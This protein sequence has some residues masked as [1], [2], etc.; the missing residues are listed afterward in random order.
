MYKRVYYFSKHFREYMTKNFKGL[1]QRRKKGNIINYKSKRNQGRK[2][3][4]DSSKSEYIT[5]NLRKIKIHFKETDWIRKMESI[6]L[7]VL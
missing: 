6:Y 2:S 3:K 4:S 1:Q 7:L 5:M